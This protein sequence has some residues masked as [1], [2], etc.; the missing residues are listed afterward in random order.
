MA[1]GDTPK[2]EFAQPSQVSEEEVLKYFED[3]DVE[4]AILTLYTAQGIM[5]MREKGGRK[6]RKDADKPRIRN[7]D[8]K[9]RPSLAMED[10][11]SS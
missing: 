11:A 6:R 4:D 7:A 1:Q 3:A 8:E 5:R 10:P 9:I 2:F